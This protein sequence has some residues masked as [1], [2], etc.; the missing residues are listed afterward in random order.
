MTFGILAAA[1]IIR[2][3]L[4]LVHLAGLQLLLVH[5]ALDMFR[6]QCMAIQCMMN[7]GWLAG[8]FW[9]LGGGLNNSASVVASCTWPL[10]CAGSAVL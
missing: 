10:A 6:I 5:L 4:L 2:F 3:Q 8:D 7:N 9:D 1:S